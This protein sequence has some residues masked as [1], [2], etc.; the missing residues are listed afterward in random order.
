MNTET[1]KEPFTYPETGNEY[2]EYLPSLSGNHHPTG[3]DSSANFM[4]SL[5]D[6][7]WLVVLGRNRDSDILTESNWEVAIQDLE[8]QGF[9]EFGDLSVPVEGEDYEKGEEKPFYSIIRH[10]HWACGWVEYLCVLAGTEA[11]KIG[12]EIHCAL[13]DYPVLDDEHYSEMEQK[14]ADN[15]WENCFCWEER[16]KY[17][18]ENRMEFEFRSFSDLLAQVRGEYFSGYA[19][20]LIQ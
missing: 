17:I 3:F 7:A 13:A 11:Q 16:I 2:S 1:E 18:R 19:N 15:I 12:E 9:T 10:G 14:E 8:S 20:E 5:P 6:K 4:G